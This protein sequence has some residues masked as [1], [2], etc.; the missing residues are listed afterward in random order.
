M[1][2]KKN[3]SV[4]SKSLLHTSWILSLLSSQREPI[5]KLQVNHPSGFLY[6]VT[7]YVYISNNVLFTFACFFDFRGNGLVP[8]VFFCDLL[9]SPLDS[10]DFFVLSR[11]VFACS[12]ALL[13]G[14]P[15]RKY[16]L[17]YS[18]CSG[19]TL[20]FLLV[21]IIT[22]GAVRKILVHFPGTMYRNFPRINTW[23][24]NCWIT[25]RA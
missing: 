9:F 11:V 17:I 23:R 25:L 3:I 8:N 19:W 7:Q 15:S 22:H 14:I 24:W 21:L 12:F 20:G 4:A 2:S 1:L 18:W 10:W 5:S 13:Y 16:A 6:S